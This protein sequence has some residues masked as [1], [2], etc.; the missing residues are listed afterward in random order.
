LDKVGLVLSGGGARGLAH[1]GVLKILEKYGL[2]PDLI[3]GTSMGGIIGGLY[4]Y[5]LTA[6][7]MENFLKNFKVSS[8]FER[9]KPLALLFSETEESKIVQ[10]V[11]MGIAWNYL[12]ARPGLDSGRKIRTF[13]G[14]LTNFAHFSD[15]KIPFACVSV[16]ITK[17]EK[18][19]LK[20]GRLCQ[21]IYATMA[22]PPFFEPLKFDNKLLLDGGILSN[23]PVDAAKE[24]GATKTITVE[25]NKLFI[26]KEKKEF[27]TAIDILFRVFDI[28]N[29]VIY[30]QEL[31]KSDLLISIE[32]EED[33]FDFKK[34]KNIIQ[35][36]EEAAYNKLP[37]L[38]KIW[39]K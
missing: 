11:K 4:S 3:V 33:I 29:D 27:K 6:N 19:V 35:K 36:G 30:S 34:Y 5:G 31:S 17:G 15:L 20:E 7:E 32:V 39:E 13:L 26:K 25:V 24:M 12:L 10:Y 1:I 37:E 16:D 38:K 28:E 14:Q 22:I 23:A 21:A 18:V 8:L 9:G 2:M